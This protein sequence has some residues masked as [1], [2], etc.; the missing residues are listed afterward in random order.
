MG[1]QGPVDATFFPAPP[2]AAFPSGSPCVR[3]MH[4]GGYSVS[5]GD[6]APGFPFSSLLSTL[7]WRAPK[8]LFDLFPWYVCQVDLW[9]LVLRSCVC[10]CVGSGASC[11]FTSP[12][13]L[14]LLPT[15]WVTGRP[16]YTADWVQEERAGFSSLFLSGLT[17]TN[18]STHVNP[19]FF[20]PRFWVHNS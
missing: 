2:V 17:F 8:L 4:V 14:S 16:N 9:V 11:L 7:S 1:V 20:F 18:V 13:S 5:I 6:R 3:V 10:V 12:L 19:L 15:V